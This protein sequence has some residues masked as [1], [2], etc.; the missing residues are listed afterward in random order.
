[1]QKPVHQFITGKFCKAGHLHHPAG[2]VVILRIH[3]IL[4]VFMR[5]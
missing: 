5:G 2:A 3:F 4:A 1:M